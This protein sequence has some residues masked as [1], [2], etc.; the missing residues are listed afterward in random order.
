MNACGAPAGAAR[1]PPEICN[2]LDDD[3]DG[4]IDDGIMLGAG[5]PCTSA[6]SARMPCPRH[7]VVQRRHRVLRH[8][9]HARRQEVCNGIDDNCNG[10]STKGR[11]PASASPAAP[12]WAPAT[13]AS[14]ACVA[15]KLV[16]SSGSGMPTA[17]VCNGLDDNCD[18][19]IDNGNFPETGTDLPLPGPRPGE[20]RRRHLQG[21]PPGLPRHARLRL[22]GL[23]AARPR[24]LRRPRQRLRRRGRH[25]PD[26]PV[27][28][29][30]ARKGA[31]RSSA[32]PASSPAPTATSASATTACRS[33]APTRPARP[34]SAATRT[35]APA[36][37][38]APASSAASPK[39]CQHGLLRRLLHARLRG[40]PD[41]QRGRL[42]GRQVRGRQ[43]RRGNQYCDDGNCVDLCTPGQVPAAAS[44]ASAASA[45]T[46]N[47]ATVALRRR[48]VLRPEDRPVPRRHLRGD[49]VRKGPALHPGDRRLRAPTRATHQLPRPVLACAR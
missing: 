1:T 2:G 30:P 45:S 31:A 28:P 40:R 35:P 9:A 13:P 25:E 15:G 21:R 18:G 19:V 16:C 23:R 8:A 46:D 11:C 41:V 36:S 33:A 14:T 44:A 43:L 37:T 22:R 27:G 20:G 49:P 48:P 10:R 17:E 39:I 3:C 12:T 5:R 47:C 29:R 38:S 34:T 42:P 6:T 32:C 24:D 26:L 4:T 7:R